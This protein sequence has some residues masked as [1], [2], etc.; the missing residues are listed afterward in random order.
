MYKKI[1]IL[2]LSIFL[3]FGCKSTNINKLT[4]QEIIDTSIKED[5]KNYNVN[6]KGYRYYLPNEFSIVKDEDYI[7][8]LLSKNNKYYLNVDIVSYYY[9]NTVS[10]ERNID[11]YEFFEFENN[12]KKGYLR[13]TKNN[14][15]FFVTLCYNYAI[16]EVEVEQDELR[17]A[18]SRSIVILNS[19]KYNDLV[20]EKYINDSDL[21]SSE[22]E[23]KI[24]EP[25]NKNESRNILEYIEEY[26]DGE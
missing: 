17:Y 22:T 7:Q 10:E 13:I 24:P 11:D 14:D 2:L 20:I 23:Y 4:L 18:V 15:Y 3:L 26:E 19:I 25:K 5:V 9:K 6:S 21:D 16:I 8:E 12:G 1:C